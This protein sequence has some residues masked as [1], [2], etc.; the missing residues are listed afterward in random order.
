MNNAAPAWHSLSDEETLLDLETSESGLTDKEVSDR[1]SQYGLNEITGKKKPSIIKVFLRQFLSPLIYV[2]LAAGII[3]LVSQF[4]TEEKHYIDAIVVFGVIILNAVIGTFQETQ[5]EKAMEALLQL[6]GAGEVMLGFLHTHPA[7]LWC[8]KC[9][10]SRWADCPLARPFFSTEDRAFHADVFP[11]AFSVALVSGDTFDAD[12]GWR[13][14]HALYGWHE[15]MMS[16]CGYHVLP[17]K[18]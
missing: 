3:S 13:V 2:L 15:G 17:E 4:F 5:A 11:R 10:S 8:G 6:R 18:A 16:E 7:R 12:Q 1:L 9:D 14:F